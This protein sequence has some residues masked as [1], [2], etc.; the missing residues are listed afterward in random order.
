MLGEEGLLTVSVTRD[1]RRRNL[2]WIVKSA[3]EWVLLLGQERDCLFS[4][5]SLT[6][7]DSWPQYVEAERRAQPLRGLTPH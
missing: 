5:P 6:T 1:I 4:S 3:E 2:V 7:K